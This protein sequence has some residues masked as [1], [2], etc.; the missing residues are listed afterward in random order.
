MSDNLDML[1]SWRVWELR[2]QNS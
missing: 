1:K 2:S